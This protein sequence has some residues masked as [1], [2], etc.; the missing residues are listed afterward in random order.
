MKELRVMHYPQVPCEGFE[1]KVDSIQQ[2]KLIM[3]TLAFYDLFQLEQNIKPD[4]SN[5]TSLEMYENGEWTDWA[6]EETGIMDIDE[7][8]EHL[9]EN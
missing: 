7:Y 3:D 9:E 1:V 4:F 2:A 5:F 8:F 6:D